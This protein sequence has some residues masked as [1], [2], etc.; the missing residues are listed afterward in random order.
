MT[1]GKNTDY[2]R[3]GRGDR[4]LREL[5]HDPYKSKLKLKE[6]TICPECGA[7]YHDGRWKWASRP[8]NA[9]EHLCPACQRIQDKLPA[10]FLTLSGQF[11]KKH[12]QEILNLVRNVEKRE[13][14]EHP[15]KRIM[16]IQEE[17]DGLSITTTDT[18]LARGIGEALF[19]AYEGE[20][21][22]HYTEETN[23]LRVSWKREH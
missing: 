15:L 11:L 20:L 17:E 10:G 19:H 9:A 13:K 14:Q 6:P 7:V 3:Q 12:Q 5:V 22:Y 8:A 1:G 21:D 18:H 23:L 16:K 2:K 4:L